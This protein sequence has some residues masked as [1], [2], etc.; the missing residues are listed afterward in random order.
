MKHLYRS[1]VLLFALTI[2]PLLTVNAA[3]QDAAAQDAAVQDAAVQDAAVQDA[4]SPTPS[5]FIVQPLEIDLGGFISK[6]ELTL[7]AD[8]EGP[9]PTVILFHGTG[10]YDMDAT[11]ITTADGE[12]LSANFRLMAERLPEAGI[13]VLRFNKRG[14][15]GPDDY[16]MA[17]VQQA[18]S[19]DQLVADA[20]AVIEAAEA[21]PEV[22]SAALYLFGWSEGAWV[23]ANAAQSHPEIAGLILQGAPD[24]AIQTILDDQWLEIGLPYLAETIDA[25][26][27]GALSIDEAATVPPGPVALMAS[28]FLYD[29][30]STPDAPLINSFVDQDGDGLIAIEDELRP[31]VEMYLS[32]YAQFAPQVESSY[33]TGEL[34]AAAEIPTLLLHG[35]NDGWVP[36]ASAEAIA[37]AAPDLVTLILYPDLGHALSETDIL[38][39]DAFLPMDDA[40]LDDLTAWIHEQER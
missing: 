15:N 3:A 27:D 9:F 26:G 18:A 38:A 33:L 25:D 5:A 12:P 28:Y 22:N 35:E 8:G 17:Q 34:I 20:A 23:A 2:F 19:L 13:A 11:Y 7:P 16:D 36:A 31:M 1:F 10:P 21:L 29:R 4:D 32:N 6:A 39:E 24:D 40:P 14:V 30:A 37:D